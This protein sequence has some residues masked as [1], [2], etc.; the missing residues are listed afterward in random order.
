MTPWPNTPT[1][2]LH[3]GK[4]RILSPDKGRHKAANRFLFRFLAA[5]QPASRLD[6]HANIV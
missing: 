3:Q 4:R 1:N 2:P 6:F 5:P